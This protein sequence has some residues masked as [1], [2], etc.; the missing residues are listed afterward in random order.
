MLHVVPPDTTPLAGARVLLHRVAADR[1]GPVDSAAADAQG[2]YR[3][4]VRPDTVALYLVSAS[5]DGIEYFGA[6]FRLGAVPPGALDVAVYDT[7]GTASVQVAARNL[8]VGAADTGGA[9]PVLELFALENRSGRTRTAPPDGA[10]WRW[11][12]PSGI[13]EFATGEGEFSS[14]AVERHGD[15]LALAAPLVPG[16]RQLVVQYLLAPRTRLVLPFGGPVP[17]VDILLAERDARVRTT[18]FAYADTQS[19][20]GRT[21]RR[22][23]GSVAAAGAVEVELPAPQSAGRGALGLL[24]AGLA[25]LLAGLGVALLRRRGAPPPLEPAPAAAGAAPRIPA[26]ALIESIARLDARY[27]GRE[28]EVSRDEWARYATERARLRAELAAAL[29]ARETGG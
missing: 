1:Q 15:S 3:V 4:S 14:R 19:V 27:A 29:A 13:R 2:R 9:R 25:V 17:S 20:D 8:V 12:L 11:P 10:S 24:V 26:A 16:A 5:W 21:Y 22:W 7:S 18:G 28:S 6:P 23:H